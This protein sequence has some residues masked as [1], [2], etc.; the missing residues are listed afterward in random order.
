MSA[1]PAAIAAAVE[2]RTEKEWR[3]WAAKEL[4]RR[5]LERYGWTCLMFAM[6]AIAGLGTIAVTVPAIYLH[7]IAGNL[8]FVLG[9]IAGPY[10]AGLVGSHPYWNRRCGESAQRHEEQLWLLNI[11]HLSAREYLETRSKRTK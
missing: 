10:N 2:R 8:V 1:S 4:S 11:G 6:S 3:L 7:N 9:L 5:R